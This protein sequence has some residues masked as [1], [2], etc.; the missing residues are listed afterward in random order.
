MVEGRL[1]CLGTQLHLKSKFGSGYKLSLTLAPG[2]PLGEMERHVQDPLVALC[3]SLKPIS[4][5]GA[6][7][8]TFLFGE[9]GTDWG[10]LF[11]LMESSEVKKW[12]SEWGLA[13]C[14]LDDVFLR[15]AGPAGGN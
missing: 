6:S 8:Y 1:K 2:C 14:S 4:S 3:P 7:Q 10:A 13:Q 11:G 9:A 12:V 5:R 15:V